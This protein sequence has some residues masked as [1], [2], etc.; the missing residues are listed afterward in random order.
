[1]ELYEK[2]QTMREEGWN[3]SQLASELGH[4]RETIRKYF[5]ASSFP[6]R[7]A[8]KLGGSIL[9]PYIP[10]LE[11][12]LQAGCEN[13]LQL[14]RE[15]QAQGYRG[16]QRQIHKW[17]QLKRTQ[18]SP[19]TPH[20]YRNLRQT[21]STKTVLPSSK[22]LAWLLVRDPVSLSE[23]DQILLHYLQQDQQIQTVYA[24][25]QRFVLIIKQRLLKALD[26]WLVES[27]ELGIT[28]FQNFAQGLQADYA[29]VRAALATTWSNGQTEGQVNR[30]K[31]IK[32]QMYGRAKFDLLRLRVLAPP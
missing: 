15:I 8:H 26:P 31:F 12:R 16:S 11:Q 19:F 4:H 20:Q 18:V 21:P 24:V 9:D 1:M 25:A 30:L 3:I 22:Q 27:N 13:A 5:Y 2:I 28:Q 7:Q 14:W 32:R 17:L 23:E 10:Y 29:A 6:E